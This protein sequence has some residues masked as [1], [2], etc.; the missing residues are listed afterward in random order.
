M[1]MSNS[2]SW[3]AYNM[4]TGRDGQPEKEREEWREKETERASEPERQTY[5]SLS[6]SP[7]KLLTCVCLSACLYPSLVLSVSLFIFMSFCLH[8]FVSACLC[9]SL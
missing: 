4:H 7:S 6:T 9:L 1:M 5:I 8:L 3:S 2:V